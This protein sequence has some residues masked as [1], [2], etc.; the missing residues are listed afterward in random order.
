MFKSS[1]LPESVSTLEFFSA[2]ITLKA[3]VVGY[4][5]SLYVSADICF[6]RRGFPADR[7]MPHLLFSEHHRGDLGIK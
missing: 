4:V 6:T 1:V 7:T 5:G 2:D 3:R